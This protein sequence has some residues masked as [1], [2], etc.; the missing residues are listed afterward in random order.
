MEYIYTTSPSVRV[1]LPN[2]LAR[3]TSK[4]VGEHGSE[5]HTTSRRRGEGG[6][7]SQ[8]ILITVEV[9]LVSG[10]A[11][12]VGVLP[13]RVGAPSIWQRV[14]TVGIANDPQWVVRKLGAVPSALLPPISGGIYHRVAMNKGIVGV[15]ELADPVNHRSRAQAIA[16]I[17]KYVICPI[18]DG[19]S[20]GES[21]GW[22]IH[23][24]Y[25]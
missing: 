13:E 23:D 7:P 10:G 18:H 20:V 4:A 5:H 16:S 12:I 15:G 22:R 17:A 11:T 2:A 3:S 24:P 21:K 25:L 19:W 1:Q 6:S 8:T 14:G 9:V